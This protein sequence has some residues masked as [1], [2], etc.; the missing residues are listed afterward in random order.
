MSNPEFDDDYYNED[1]ELAKEGKEVCP[2]CRGKGW[3]HG[4]CDDPYEPCSLCR[5]T[6]CIERV[7]M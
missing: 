7:E 1:Y 3:H 6:G 2:E 4:E 5:K